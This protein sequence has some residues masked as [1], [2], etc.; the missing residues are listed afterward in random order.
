MEGTLNSPRALAG[1]NQVAWIA[2]SLTR[3][4]KT[5]DEAN[6]QQALVFAKGKVGSFVGNGWEWPYALDEKLGNPALAPVVGRLSDAEPHPGQVHA[7]RSSAAPT[8]P[9]R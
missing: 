7:R 5:T 8:S 9:S 2:K 1:L 4:S 3:A 6:P